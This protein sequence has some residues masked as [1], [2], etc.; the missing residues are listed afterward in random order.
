A[1]GEVAD[2][3]QYWLAQDSSAR[4]YAS[5][6]YVRWR[7]SD[8]EPEEGK[9]AWKEDENYKKLIKGALDRGLK[10]AFRIYNNARDNLRQS[11]PDFVR[12]A[13]AKGYTVQGGGA[14][15]W[16]PY[17][18][19]PIFQEKLTNFVKAFAAEY[20]NPDIVDFVDGVNVGRWGECHGLEIEN[21][22][23][24]KSD[25]ALEKIT[26]IYGENFKRVILIMPVNSQFGHDSE[27]SIAVGKNGYGF[28]RD[29][30]GSQW[31][32]S[33]EK[34]VV[35]T[36]Y[37]STLLIGESCYWMGNDSDSLWF[38]DNLYHFK[39]WREIYDQT[40]K[41]AIDYH[42]NTLDLR[43]PIETKRWT[44]KTSDLVQ[45][46]IEK[47]GYRLYPSKVS[48]PK[49]VKQN[50]TFVVG[51]KWRNLSNGI[52]PNDNPRWNGKY[53]VAFA[54]LDENANVKQIIVDEKSNPAK[55]L[56]G[57]DVSYTK[58]V[59]L[60][61]LAVG[62]YTFA[63]AIVDTTKANMPGLKLSTADQTI[64]GWTSIGTITII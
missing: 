26:N 8:M 20:D 21:M 5:F 17:I 31:F 22:T 27:M 6:F 16:T 46:F 19:D 50:Q 3:S 28:R 45:K 42:F 11:T 49:I 12:A 37:P 2:A 38:D 32:S 63:I 64:N 25:A 7:W 40:Y 52:C 34:S 10:L 36:L 1:A 18:D 30:L 55:F 23:K 58:S 53:K 24:A 43:T 51:H 39:T 62:K 59:T 15:Y 29:G 35:K 48:I 4:K 44:A 61:N 41:D 57:I 9:Y 54:L 47:G 56:Q 60:N 33:A 13:G 14:K